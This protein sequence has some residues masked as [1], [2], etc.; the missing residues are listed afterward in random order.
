MSENFAKA[1]MSIDGIMSFLY[2]IVGEIMQFNDYGKYGSFE[3][4]LL[5]LTIC[6]A[7]LEHECLLKKNLIDAEKTK[8]YPSIRREKSSNEAANKELDLK[9]LDLENEQR[10]EESFARS[11]SKKIWAYIKR[12][13]YMDTFFWREYNKAKAI[14]PN[15]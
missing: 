12:S 2:N 8:E 9:Y 10:E 1:K 11:V 13:K 15:M 14:M 7:D 3:K 5:E 4:T 6:H